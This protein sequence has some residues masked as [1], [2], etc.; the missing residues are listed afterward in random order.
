MLQILLFSPKK[1]QSNYN[2]HAEADSD[3]TFRAN[4]SPN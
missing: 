1:P 2:A 3:G 4:P